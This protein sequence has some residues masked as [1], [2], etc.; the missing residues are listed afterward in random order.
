MV[1]ITLTAE[2]LAAALEGF[3]AKK[4]RIDA[5]IE[6]IR[7]MLEVGRR[8]PVATSDTER[9]KRTRSAAVR[10]RM[11]IAQQLR[12]KKIKENVEPLQPAATSEPTKP[13]RR[14][15]A[16]ARRKMAL[17]QKAW[18]AAV[19][20]ASEPQRAVV[21]KAAANKVSA[22]KTA[23]NRVVRPEKA[24]KKTVTAKPNAATKP[25]QEVLA[26]TAAE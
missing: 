20:A 25:R 13:K 3:E 10:R 7:G 17:A 22:K 26:K 4:N 23:A 16:S 15:S 1:Q 6:E 9:L 19:K 21:R 18:W 14:V 11:K 5:R 12:W 2:L 24:V 8:E